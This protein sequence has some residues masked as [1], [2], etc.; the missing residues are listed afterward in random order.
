M[1]VLK[2][3]SRLRSTY[4]GEATIDKVTRQNERCLVKFHGVYWSAEAVSPFF[5]H[6]ND[7]VKVVGRRGL[8]LLIKPFSARTIGDYR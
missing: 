3:Q 8:V 7:L 1:P 2:N 6:S 4:S 5:L